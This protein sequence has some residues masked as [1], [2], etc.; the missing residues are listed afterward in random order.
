M[1]VR[2][3]AQLCVVPTVAATPRLEVDD[4]R[5]GDYLVPVTEWDGRSPQIALVGVPQD[6]GVAR[7]GGRRGAAAAPAAI[8]AALAKLAAS[9]GETMLPRQVSICDCGLVRTEGLSLE[10]IHQRQEYIVGHFLAMGAS[11]LVLGGGHD[12]AL[13][14]GR[15][16]GKRVER[17]GIVN[18]DAHLDVRIPT[19]DGSHSGSPFRELIED[20]ACPL[21]VLIELGTQRF[22]ASAHHV[23]YVREHGHIVWMLDDIRRNTLEIVLADIERR[24]AECDGIMLSLD[25]DALASA[26]APGVSAPANDGFQ[27]AEV[28]AIIERI[29]SMP[30]CRLVDIVEVN[31]SVDADERTVRLA[32]YFAALTMW[33]FAHRRDDAN[34][35]FNFG[36][37]SNDQ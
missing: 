31:P 33:T 34:S 36:S 7:N 16:L 6:I 15:A 1:H 9:I 4:R 37:A 17:L 27:P 30:Q 3:I 28:A 5:F 29:V 23:R 19:D 32:A 21:E 10:E 25:V 35:P 18:V 20:A 24:L 8:R 22:A 13:P 12:T 14:D 2:D 11:V 26:Y